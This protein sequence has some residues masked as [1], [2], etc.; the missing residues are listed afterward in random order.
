MNDLVI[1]DVNVFGDT[2]KAARDNEGVIWVGLNAFCRGLNMDKRRRDYQIEK[3]KTD[4]MLSRGC[5][6]FRAGVF[7]IANEAYALRIDFVPTWLAKITITDKMEKDHPELAEKLLNYQLKAKDILAQAFLPET[8]L[9]QTTDGKIQLLAQGITETNQKVE[10]LTNEMKSVK[11]DIST[12]KT[13]IERLKLD[14]PLLPVEAD[15]VS[16]AVKK[17]VVEILGG[18]K[19]RAYHDKSICQMAF[20]D[21]YKELKRQF[22]V[23]SYKNIKRGQIDNAIDV[24]M[25]YE[26]PVFL[27]EKIAGMNGKQEV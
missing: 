21:A 5:R 7:D 13:E 19:S 26:P 17:R 9:P 8:S 2:I 27:K 11:T 4:K 3:T 25:G 6:K 20:S 24:A 15:N 12:A 18:K 1:K 10:K 14:L 22:G 23:R 16:S